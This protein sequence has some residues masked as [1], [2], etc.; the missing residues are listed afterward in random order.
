MVEIRGRGFILALN[1]AR[2]AFTVGHGRTL[3]RIADYGATLALRH[4]E[5][6]LQVRVGRSR[7]GRSPT[8]C[9][10]I[11]QSLEVEQVVA[12][13]ARYAAELL[14]AHSARVDIIEDGRLVTAATFGRAPTEWLGGARRR[15]VV[16]GR[17]H[18]AP[19]Q[20]VASGVAPLGR[21]SDVAGVRGR[22]EA[23]A[24]E[25]RRG[26]VGLEWAVDRRA[27]GLR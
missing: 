10:Q 25:C 12:R 11:N 9:G 3:Q 21:R 8:R 6:I 27:D 13:L 22:R 2:D 4:A 24:D 14:N 17:G 26:S 23:T 7:R 16:R 18:P 1:S 20:S 19:T 5:L 15:V